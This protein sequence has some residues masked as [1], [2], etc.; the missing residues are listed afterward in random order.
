MPGGYLAKG[1]INEL[2]TRCPKTNIVVGGYSQGAMVARVGTAWANESAKK[3][4]KG[5]VL[6]GDPFNGATVKGVPKEKVKIFCN[7]SD[8]VCKGALSIGVG[9]LSYTSNGDVKK[10]ADWC[11]Q[12]VGGS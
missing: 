11:K 7:D 3:M 2:N 1:V 12:L 6:Y 5:L 10:G 9:H 4:I 8:G